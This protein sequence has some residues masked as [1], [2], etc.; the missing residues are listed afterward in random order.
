MPRFKKQLSSKETSAGFSEVFSNVV[1]DL[2]LLSV[3]VT[4]N[5]AKAINCFPPP[6]KQKPF[7]FLVFLSL[8]VEYLCK[9]EKMLCF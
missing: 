3:H 8:C 1:L 7:S 4:S 9:E 2:F 6:L 5:F